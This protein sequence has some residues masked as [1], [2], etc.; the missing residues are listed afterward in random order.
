[1]LHISARLVLSVF[2]SGVQDIDLPEQVDAIVS[3][4][5]VSPCC[6]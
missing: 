3:E 4:W 1:V 5:M 6:F 2:V